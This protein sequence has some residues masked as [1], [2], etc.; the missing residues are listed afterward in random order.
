V[1]NILRVRWTIV[2]RILPEPWLTCSR[3]GCVK[4][5][6]CSE[7]FRLNANGKRLDAWLVYRCR[8]CDNSWN[9]PIF[10]RR[11]LYEVDPQMLQALQANDPEWVR[12]VGFD[13]AGLAGRVDRVEETSQLDL[14]RNLLSAGSAPISV[15][16]ILIAVAGPIALRTDRLLAA[17]FG[18]SRQRLQD[19]ASAGRLAVTPGGEKALRRPVRDGTC[20]AVD[21]ANE[22]TRHEIS[23]AAAIGD[24]LDGNLCF[25]ALTVQHGG[26]DNG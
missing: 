6:R 2:P 17:E 4:P 10:E 15:L 16:E 11:N 14:R 7:K 24:D 1:S 5:F 25:N 8:D 22:G 13:L 12:R 20:I 23:R 3:C 18:V 26:A 19:L 9:R 21:L